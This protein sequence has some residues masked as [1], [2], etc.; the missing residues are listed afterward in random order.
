M[1]KKTSIKNHEL[2]HRGFIKKSAAAGAV[3]ASGTNR[4]FAA[5][6]DE[7]R[8]GFIGCGSGQNKTY[9]VPV[10]ETVFVIPLKA[11]IQFFALD[12]CFCRGDIID[13]RFPQQILFNKFL[14]TII[15]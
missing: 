14:L 13:F 10:A 15:D 11:G 12:P 1:R 9:L 2:T 4:I 5:G 3:L 6:S 7:L 8:I